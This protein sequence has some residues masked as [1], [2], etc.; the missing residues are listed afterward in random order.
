MK[1]FSKL[2]FILFFQ[3]LICGF[4][5]GATT[6]DSFNVY[7]EINSDYVAP[8]PGR[9]GG[10]TPPA[11]T[12]L[13]ISQADAQNIT[14]QSADINVS[15]NQSATCILDWGLDQNYGN[16]ITGQGEKTSH[17]FPISGLSG[18]KKYYFKIACNN[19]NGTAMSSGNSF[20]TIAEPDTIPPQNVSQFFAVAKDAKIDLSWI[21][22]T[23]SDF[24]GLI[25]KRSDS[26]IITNRNQGVLI[27]EG[28][29]EIFLDTGLINDR[30]YYYAIFTYDKVKNYSSG[31]VAFAVPKK[32]EEEKEEEKEIEIPV[33]DDAV[34]S[35]SDDSRSGGST[36]SIKDLLIEK[37]LQKEWKEKVEKITI[38]DLKVTQNGKN[39]FE[40]ETQIISADKPLDVGFDCAQLP[41]FVKVV[42]L[43]LGKDGK[44]TSFVLCADNKQDKMATMPPKEEGKYSLTIL[45]LDYQNQIV[46]KL[47]TEIQILPPTFP[48]APKELFWYERIIFTIGSLWM[49]WWGK[50]L[51]VISL[52]FV[53]LLIALARQQERLAVFEK[54]KR[55]KI[56][57][58]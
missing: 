28:K 9:G 20:Q 54:F 15:L 24:D 52:L 41:P 13:E 23:D 31:A 19:A 25:L 4:C 49:L 57:I 22:P 37:E 30:T 53:V 46:K 27:Y 33:L 38:Q 11:P 18:L 39:I 56:E 42:V 45:F 32:E 40:Q 50:L 58:D 14:Y 48:K 21:N 55:R 17:I 26:S 3:I 51:I 5:F 7:L 34:S 29:D 47:E 8:D 12:P 36:T 2:L 1:F 44:E 43:S 10:Q 16:S 6:S 35:G